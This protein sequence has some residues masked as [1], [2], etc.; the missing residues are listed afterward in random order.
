[1]RKVEATELSPQQHLLAEIIQRV[2]G[3][4]CVNDVPV[5]SNA[6]QDVAQAVV[7]KI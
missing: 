4:S 1:M 2:C 5:V 3:L 6:V 7:R